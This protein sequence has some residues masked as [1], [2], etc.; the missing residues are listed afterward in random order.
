MAESP[1]TMTGIKRIQELLDELVDR[2]VEQT[3]SFAVILRD[4]LAVARDIRDAIETLH[5][6]YHSTNKESAGNVQRVA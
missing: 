3:E 2:E 5:S 4:I 6:T 1:S